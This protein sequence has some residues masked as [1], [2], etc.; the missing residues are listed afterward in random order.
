VARR[1]D[2]DAVAALEC[3]RLARALGDEI[4]VAG[5]GDALARKAE[6]GDELREIGGARGQLVAVDD[7]F[8]ID[9]RVRGQD[10]LRGSRGAKAAAGRLNRIRPESS[11]YKPMAKGDRVD[12]SP[13]PMP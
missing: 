13:R 2:L 10:A 3:R 7:D 9:V 6:L 11:R 5:R 12:S 1:D 8:A 4:A